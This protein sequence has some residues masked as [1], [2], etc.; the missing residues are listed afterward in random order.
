MRGHPLC[1]LLVGLG[2]TRGG[3]ETF[4]VHIR[5]PLLPWSL[6]RT[7]ISH[8]VCGLT[9]AAYIKVISVP[10]EAFSFRPC[11]R[12]HEQS[13][14]RRLLPTRLPARTAQRVECGRDR[15]V[16]KIAE[17]HLEELGASSKE[18]LAQQSRPRTLLA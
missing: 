10:R 9:I 5:Y 3:L 4:H 11:S 14:G 18:A 17:K 1:Y 8:L 15:N 2:F 7:T 12:F 6:D 13:A 16:F